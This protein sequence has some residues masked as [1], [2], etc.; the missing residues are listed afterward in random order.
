MITSRYPVWRTNPAGFAVSGHWPILTGVLA[1]L[2]GPVILG[3]II[4]GLSGLFAIPSTTGPQTA[5]VRALEAFGIVLVGS[6]F[7]SWLALAF[8]I[9]ISAI[10]ATRGFAGWGVAILGGF[11]VG[12][13]AAIVMGGFEPSAEMLM[14]GFVGLVLALLYWGAIRLVHPTAIGVGFKAPLT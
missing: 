5:P 6:P 14:M 10:A 7:I 9:P 4:V 12:I 11:T 13:L 3:T 2:I 1:V 8:A